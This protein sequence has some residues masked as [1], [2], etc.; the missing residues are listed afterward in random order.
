M[1]VHEPPESLMPEEGWRESPR[2]PNF[3]SVCNRNDK[4]CPRFTPQVG[5]LRHFG[6]ADGGR[7]FRSK[8]QNRVRYMTGSELF[9]THFCLII[10][11]LRFEKANHHK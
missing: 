8:F 6:K 1:E 3:P 9:Y 2:I 5:V 10:L 7:K 4:Q 11:S